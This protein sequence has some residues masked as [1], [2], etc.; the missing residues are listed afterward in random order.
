MIVGEESQANSS[1]HT[2]HKWNIEIIL[3]VLFDGVAAKKN[4]FASQIKRRDNFASAEATRAT[5]PRL[6]RLLKK[7]GENFHPVEGD[8]LGGGQK[9][10]SLG[11]HK[12]VRTP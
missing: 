9:L 12:L 5:R 2:K 11:R 8:R 3:S 1:S 6:R 4:V 10:S 7:A